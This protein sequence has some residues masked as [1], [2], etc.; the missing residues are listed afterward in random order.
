MVTTSSTTNV[1]HT[2]LNFKLYTHVTSE[3]NSFIVTQGATPASI[4]VD[5]ELTPSTLEGETSPC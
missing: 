2:L 4:I 3:V 1:T 5:E